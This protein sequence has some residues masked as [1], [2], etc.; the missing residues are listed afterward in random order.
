MP[1]AQLRAY[2]RRNRV[3]EQ[4]PGVD[5]RRAVEAAFEV[6]RS[7]SEWDLDDLVVAIAIECATVVADDV[8]QFERDLSAAKLANRPKARLS[9]GDVKR[10][11][12]EFLDALIAQSRREAETGRDGFYDAE[13]SRA[14]DWLEELR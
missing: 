8:E 2:R 1:A 3:N 4:H 5:L 14:G 10:I 7:R 9:P 13:I 11:R 6:V 12:R